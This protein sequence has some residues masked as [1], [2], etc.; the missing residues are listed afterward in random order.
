[1]KRTYQELRSTQPEVVEETR[2]EPQTP[3]D[4]EE[5]RDRI[6]QLCEGEILQRCER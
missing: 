4:R 2:Q 1:M 3:A 6:P 5:P